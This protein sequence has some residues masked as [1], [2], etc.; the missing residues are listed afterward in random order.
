MSDIRKEVRTTIGTRIDKLVSDAQEEIYKLKYGYSS[1]EADLTICRKNL[2]M[3]LEHLRNL[4]DI[5]TAYAALNA[6]AAE[7]MIPQLMAP[8]LFEPSELPADL[9][10][11]S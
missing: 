8:A 1:D 9:P 3:A 6:R 4:E 7:L 2:S 11:A 10:I 5:E